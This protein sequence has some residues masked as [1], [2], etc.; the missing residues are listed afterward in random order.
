MQIGQDTIDEIVR[1]FNERG[2]RLG[3]AGNIT[4]D[5]TR[6]ILELCK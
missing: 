6:R 1:R 3:E 4:G 5:V 2:S